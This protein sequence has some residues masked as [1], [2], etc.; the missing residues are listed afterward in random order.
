MRSRTGQPGGIPSSIACAV[1]ALAVAVLSCID[2]E[3]QV[4]SLLLTWRHPS[5]V[6]REWSTRISVDGKV[7]SSNLGSNFDQVCKLSEVYLEENDVG[8]LIELHR[9]I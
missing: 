7:E 5:V 2:A 3:E 4:R 8:W 9:C 1:L 6:G